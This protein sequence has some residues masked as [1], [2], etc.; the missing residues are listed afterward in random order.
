MTSFVK[1]KGKSQL[2][3]LN[4]PFSGANIAVICQHQ[5]ELPVFK[6]SLWKLS[7]KETKMGFEL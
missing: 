3:L 2:I 5:R 6:S 1:E 4:S 7:E